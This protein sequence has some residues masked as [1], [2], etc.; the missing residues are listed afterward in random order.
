MASAI[1]FDVFIGRAT[2]ILLE[3]A[4]GGNRISI[5]QISA[6]E[7]DV[8]R[9]IRLE[10]LRTEPSSFASRYED[11][12][13]LPAG[14]WRRR[15][16]D[17]VFVAFTADEPV[18]IMGLSR[19]RP[20]KMAHRA[21]LVM[22]YLRTNFRG[23][24]LASDLLDVVIEFAGDEGILQLELA[25][26]AENP[27]AIGFYHR[28]GFSEVGRIPGGLLEGGREIDDLIMVRRLSG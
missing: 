9:R 2:E 20:C 22:V 18:G 28:E 15:L 17:P 12:V 23:T 8:F 5:R 27:G 1:D 10:A 13:D 3:A 21:T 14:D 11:W 4:M 19:R 24:G 26:S 7:I 6:V 25:V 16:H